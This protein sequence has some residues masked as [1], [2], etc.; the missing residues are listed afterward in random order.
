MGANA[1]LGMFLWDMSA[2]EQRFREADI[3]LSRWGSERNVNAQFVIQPY[4]R[5]D[6]LVRFA[7]P[8]GRTELSFKWSPGRL[9][10]RAKLHR[11]LIREHTF[12]EGVPVPGHENVRLNA[13]LYRSVP[14]TDGKPVNICIERFEFIPLKHR[15]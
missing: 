5:P 2:P 14:P 12:T 4:T 13:W 10:C 9:L 7:L 11:K 8:G 15:G 3:E 1:V 6:N